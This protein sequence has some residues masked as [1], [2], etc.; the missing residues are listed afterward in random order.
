MCIRDRYR[1]IRYQD[2]TSNACNFYGDD[3]NNLEPGGLGTGPW[4]TKQKKCWPTGTWQAC[5]T[6]HAGQVIAIPSHW[7]YEQNDSP[8]AADVEVRIVNRVTKPGGGYTEVKID[9]ASVHW[10]F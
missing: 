9:A 2:A 7:A 8:D 5:D 6:R 10:D 4:L 1:A 3:K